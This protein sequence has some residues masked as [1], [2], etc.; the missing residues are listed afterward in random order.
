MLRRNKLN[1]FS[2]AASLTEDGT[3]SLR[4]NVTSQHKLLTAMQ[5]YKSSYETAKIEE[6]TK[7][8]SL[9]LAKNGYVS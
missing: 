5:K 1:L 9:D 2:L 6:A 3:P 7:R 4:I 8:Q